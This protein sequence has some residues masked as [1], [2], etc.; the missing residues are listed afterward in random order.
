MMQKYQLW[1]FI[2]NPQLHLWLYQVW[3]N[4]T[5]IFVLIIKTWKFNFYSFQCNNAIVCVI[6]YSF[7][8]FRFDFRNYLI[9]RKNPRLPKIEIDSRYIGRFS[10]VNGRQNIIKRKW[11]RWRAL[12]CHFTISNGRQWNLEISYNSK[13]L[14]FVPDLFSLKWGVFME[15]TL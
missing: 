6:S 10:H 13:L 7:C 2:G 11:V 9:S 4:C 14:Q 1:F 12:K 8:N 15:E 3:R 5:S